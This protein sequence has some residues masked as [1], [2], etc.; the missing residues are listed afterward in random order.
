[1][2]LSLNKVLHEISP[3]TVSPPSIPAEHELRINLCEFVLC[4]ML[5]EPVPGELPVPHL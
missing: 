5:K 1:M 3:G 2:H 4:N